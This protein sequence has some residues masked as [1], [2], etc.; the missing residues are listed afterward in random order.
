MDTS[1]SPKR[2]DNCTATAFATTWDARAGALLKALCAPIPPIVTASAGGEVTHVPRMRSAAGSDGTSSARQGECESQ[3]VVRT[4][5]EAGRM[6]GL[7][8]VLGPP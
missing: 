1:P 8:P 2:L 7:R 4:L 3:R 5:D 6:V